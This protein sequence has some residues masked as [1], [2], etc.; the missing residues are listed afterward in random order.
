MGRGFVQQ[1]QA[2]DLVLDSGL[3]VVVQRVQELSHRFPAGR[4]AVENGLKR[5]LFDLEAHIPVIG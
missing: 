5:H 4:I 3:A 1:V 2:L